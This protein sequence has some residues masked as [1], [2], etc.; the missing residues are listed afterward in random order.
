MPNKNKNKNKSNNSKATKAPR[1]RNRNRQNNVLA[2]LVRMV[3]DPCKAPLVPGLYGETEGYLTKFH[4]S[5]NAT[6]G[7]CGYIVWFPDMM[8]TIGDV[9][10]NLSVYMPT[11]GNPDLVPLNTVQ[12]PYGSGNMFEADVTASEITEPAYSFVTAT[13]DGF[14]TLSACMSLNYTG[15]MDATQG[16]IAVLTGVPISTMFSGSSHVPPTVNRLFTYAEGTQRLSLDGHEVKWR[17][18]IPLTISSPLVNLITTQP[19]IM[20]IIRMKPDQQT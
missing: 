3:Q 4:K 19:F 5:T 13:T 20:N 18:T 15:R 7:P 17:P 16:E 14:R 6:L 1:K 12:N 2:P 11:A 8:G 10:P 9:G